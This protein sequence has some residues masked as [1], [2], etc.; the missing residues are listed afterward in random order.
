M[1]HRTNLPVICALVLA[2]LAGP[3]RAQPQ[4][5][6]IS[7]ILTQAW[8]DTGWQLTEGQT[9]GVVAN[10]ILNWYPNGCPTT[11][12]CV[13]SPNGDP[14][15]ACESDS[16]AFV[17]PGL[18]CWSLIGRIGSNGPPFQ[19][20]DYLSFTAQ[21]SGEFFLGVNDNALQNNTGNWSA[22]ILT[23]Y[24]LSVVPPQFTISTVAGNGTAGFSGDGG[25]ALSAE[26]N[27]PQGV[28]VDSAGNLYIAD[29]SNNRIRRVAPDG[30]ITTVA[31]NGSAGFSGD[32][33]Q[34]TSAEL[35]QP[36]RVSV[37]ISGN[38]YIAD[39]FNNRIRKVDTNGIITTVAG[40][41][42]Q[43]YSG[44]GGP[45]TSASLNDPG[46]AVSDPAGNL[47]IADEN[48]V[49]RKVDTHGIITTV[50]GN[51]AKGY[52][53]DGGPATS[54]SLNTPVG[55]ALG[56]TGDLYISDQGNNRIRKVSG[57]TIATVAGNGKPGY[58]G[59]GG[60]ATAA[61]LNGV[62]CI[63]IDA[64]G[65][66]YIPENANNRIRAVSTD[67]TIWT[68]AGDGLAGY[69]GD[70]GVATGTSLNSPRGVAI[71]HSG[72]IYIA[73]YSN[74][75]VRLLTPGPPAP[76]V[77]NPS[78]ETPGVEGCPNFKYQPS[79]AAWTFSSNAGITAAGCTKAFNA[80]MAPSGGGS[81]VAFIQAC[82]GPCGTFLSA[83][84]PVTLSQTVAGFLAGHSYQIV[85]YAAGRPAGGGC[86]DSCTEL[87][88]SVLV[89]PADVLDV[90]NP[91][92]AAF[93]RYKTK[94]FTAT[95]TA[96]ISF[97]GTAQSQD[98]T[99]FVDLV[100]IQDVTPPPQPPAISAGGVVS[101]SAFGEFTS[102]SPG[103]WIE[104][105]GSNLAA[106]SRSWLASDFAGVDAPT[107]LDGT[108]VTI[109]DQ[110]AFVDFISPGQVNVL[111]PS[112]VATGTQPMTVTV[113]NVTSA[114]YSISVNP[115]EP[116][117]DA[118]PSFN[119]GG[120]Q[121][122]VALFADGTYVLPKGAIPG[123]NSRPAQP[124]DEIV[125][126]G[127][128]F[129][130]VAPSIPAGQL[131]QQ[132]NT[133]ASDFSMSIGGT[134]VTNMPYSGLAPNFTGLYQFNIVV[135]PGTGAGA[136]PLTFTVNGVAGTQTLYLAVGG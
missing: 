125:L 122:V 79:G 70:G 102:V 74:Q 85:F 121:Y 18:A 119:I 38:L 68:V 41:G 103:S 59:D 28:A 42:V 99:S 64:A 15:S 133:L 115:V 52:S 77:G 72:S 101:A 110:A 50:A 78:F 69:S 51:G 67:G 108:S 12:A 36:N 96:T 63:A 82:G 32:S 124:G 29:D 83:T 60:P 100:S 113:G 81:Q 43:G 114:A 95:G 31:G 34:A 8:T 112:N 5:K 92:T 134:P 106:D 94:T 13:T 105:Y 130:P 48:D 118:P 66:L 98:N 46:D 131:V 7:V 40:N 86:S 9:V 128:G 111:V 37:D 26:V 89:G 109:G 93:Q 71:G 17:A 135:P 55:V 61:E 132:A 39:S 116:G 33:G 87:N 4:E 97:S 62:A 25:P 3:A 65:E 19:V 1:P 120:T 35:N 88:F 57:G 123:L 22:T 56:A 24:A 107:S 127:I 91:P 16:P 10:G 6:T 75:R 53:G 129:G 30:T 76:S 23:P 126:Y 58:A 21:S 20:G 90:T 136:V 80:P 104:I 47:F 84:G 49:V 11:G 44:D 73:D 45:A 54:A 117:F 14:W 27:E 2:A